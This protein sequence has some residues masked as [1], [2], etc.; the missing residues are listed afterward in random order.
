MYVLPQIFF[1]AKIPAENPSR[2]CRNPSPSHK[3]A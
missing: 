3:Y 1:L 2:E